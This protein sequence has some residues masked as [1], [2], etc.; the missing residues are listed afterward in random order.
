MLDPICVDL[1]DDS[2]LLEQALH[3]ALAEFGRSTIDA[4][5]GPGCEVDHHLVAID[6]EVI[7]TVET[8]LAAGPG[9]RLYA[10]EQTI[11]DP[12]GLHTTVYELYWSEIIALSVGPLRASVERVRLAAD[13]WGAAYQGLRLS[14]A[15][16]PR[17][18]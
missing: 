15:A 2:K 17:G 8:A 11:V 1:L 10:G 18:P 12:V 3:E 4:G 6:P 14:P 7:A 13:Q 16:I 5:D 9:H